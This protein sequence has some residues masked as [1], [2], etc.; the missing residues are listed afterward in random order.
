M[1][2][3]AVAARLADESPAILLE[4]LL[5][6]PDLHLRESTTGGGRSKADAHPR[7]SPH[8]TVTAGSQGGLEIT[9]EQVFS[10]PLRQSSPLVAL[11]AKGCEKRLCA[12]SSAPKGCRAAPNFARRK[13]VDCGSSSRPTRPMT[14]PDWST[15]S[16]PRAPP[17]H[18]HSEHQARCW[19]TTSAS[20]SRPSRFS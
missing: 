2:V 11:P 17:T 8:L 18:S 6:G 19:S 12:G 16:S 13:S 15:C 10:Y 7:V 3:L 1:P 5:D 9:R 14:T 20:G 4:F